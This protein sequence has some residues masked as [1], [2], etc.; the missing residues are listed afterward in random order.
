[1]RDCADKAWGLFLLF[2]L[3]ASV[4][5]VLVAGA[6]TPIVVPFLLLAL[7]LSFPLWMIAGWIMRWRDR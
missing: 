4:P 7:V 1:V 5:L 3:W 2:L 6:L